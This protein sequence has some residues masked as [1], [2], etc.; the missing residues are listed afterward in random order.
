MKK[1]F[2]YITTLVA[3]VFK[4]CKESCIEVRLAGRN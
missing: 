3:I 4:A 2:I 1:H